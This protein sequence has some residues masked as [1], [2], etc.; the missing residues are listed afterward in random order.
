RS[1]RSP[2]TLS[3]VSP[4]RSTLVEVNT[5]CGNFSTSKKSAPRSMAVCC[6]SSISMLLVSIVTFTELLP[7]SASSTRTVPC[8]FL[9]PPVVRKTRLSPIAKSIVPWSL[10]I[11]SRSDAAR[12]CPGAA[13]APAAPANRER[14]DKLGGNR[15]LLEGLKVAPV[16]AALVLVDRALVIGGGQRHAHR[17]RH[18]ARL[19]GRLA[20]HHAAVELVEIDDAQQRPGVGG[21][22]FVQQQPALA[23]GAVER[24]AVHQP[25]VVD[26][27]RAR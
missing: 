13:R 5:I 8:H 20:Q 11:V 10:L 21:G 12:P 22:V 26:G 17:R 4:V 6:G 2:T 25:H 19:D 15:R 7:T 23:V 27:H 16:G 1:S 3:V 18:D 9:K 24:R 14:R